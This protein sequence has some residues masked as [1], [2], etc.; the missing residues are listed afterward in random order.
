M[1]PNWLLFKKQI[2]SIDQFPENTFGFIYKITHVDTNKV[3]VGSTVDIDSRIRHHIAD[4]E[5]GESTCK[6]LQRLF[7]EKPEVVAVFKETPDRDTAYMEEQRFIDIYRNKSLLLNIGSIDA[8]RPFSG[9][10]HTEETLKKMS[11]VKTGKITSDETKAKLSKIHTGRVQ[12]EEQLRLQREA[13]VLRRGVPLSPETKEKMS[14][15]LDN[16]V[17]ESLEEEVCSHLE[18]PC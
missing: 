7:D 17:K 16:Q 6:P 3:Y 18:K 14:I 11:E 5:R 8:K 15:T 2:E 4:L 1:T 12:S 9:L 10:K 13:M